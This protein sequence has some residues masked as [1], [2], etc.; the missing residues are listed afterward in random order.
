MSKT[1]NT[2]RN[3]LG[4]LA[5]AATALAVLVGLPG[6]EYQP[7]SVA[8][9]GVYQIGFKFVDHPGQEAVY[10]HEGDGCVAY[11]RRP[12]RSELDPYYSG[13]AADYP[14]FQALGG[15]IL[16]C[17]QGE[18]PSSDRLDYWPTDLDFEGL[19]HVAFTLDR[20]ICGGPEQG[21]LGCNISFKEDDNFSQ[22]EIVLP[23]VADLD[24]EGIVTR[25]N[26]NVVFGHELFHSYCRP[27]HDSKKG[28]D[29][30]YETV[31]S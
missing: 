27:F 25:D 15:A 8:E 28:G 22:I 3:L 11:V 26:Y 23:T 31:T 21:I 16:D 4:S 7:P 12:V 17:I 2:I 13:D 20:S 30:C 5:V 19:I 10:Y 29:L 24:P 1:S 6:H 18:L 9:Q 14:G